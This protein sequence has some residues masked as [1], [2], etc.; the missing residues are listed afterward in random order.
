[1]GGPALLQKKTLEGV[2]PS[3]QQKKIQELLKK[4][5]AVVRVD[6]GIVHDDK[7]RKAANGVMGRLAESD[8]DMTMQEFLATLMRTHPED[9]KD[10]IRHMNGA[11]RKGNALMEEIKEIGTEYMNEPVYQKAYKK[12]LDTEILLD[13]ARDIYNKEKQDQEA[14]IRA[15]LSASRKGL[16]KEMLEEASELKTRMTELMDIATELEKKAQELSARSKQLEKPGRVWSEEEKKKRAGQLEK[17]HKERSELIDAINEMRMEI[18]GIAEYASEIEKRARSNQS[19]ISAWWGLSEAGIQA[20]HLL[21]SAEVLGNKLNEIEGRMGIRPYPTIGEQSF[22]KPLRPKVLQV[23]GTGVDKLIVPGQLHYLDLERGNIIN[24]VGVQALDQMYLRLAKG[25]RRIRFLE[26]AEFW[27]LVPLLPK[28]DAILKDMKVWKE[29][30]Y[31]EGFVVRV[32]LNLAFAGL[33]VTIIGKLATTTGARVTGRDLASSIAK[34]GGRFA[35]TRAERDVFL[36]ALQGLEKKDF[37]DLWR[38]ARPPSGGGLGWRRVCN[39][40]AR[41]A[42]SRRIT[43]SIIEEYVHQQTK[44]M[45]GIRHIWRAKAGT[46]DILSSSRALTG[47]ERFM[48]RVYAEIPNELRKTIDRNA[49]K[50]L[51][52]HLRSASLSM[53]E[54]RIARDSVFLVST[55]F[56][57]RAQ[58][59]LLKVVREKG[60]RYVAREI[61]SEIYAAEKQGIENA[62]SVGMKKGLGRV[63]PEYHAAYG[64][65]PLLKHV[66]GHSAAYFVIAPIVW[67]G[68][69]KVLGEVFP[70][71]KVGVVYTDLSSEERAM[72]AFRK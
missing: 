62:L 12:I 59:A 3:P 51:M 70:E 15:L 64:V 14:G 21:G 50:E 52:A 38:L 67:L 35:L 31:P 39:D 32:M 36:E 44:S 7:F 58:R 20:R 68:A 27:E 18:S 5:E 29:H 66:F 8:P 24:E 61:R 55:S 37:A 56:S 40:L 6:L 13:V 22:Y 57:P 46:R 69:M 60:W 41:F 11:I 43:A 28:F 48:Q 23:P 25:E 49:G 45:L 2:V 4:L 47:K 17:L 30:G 16:N 54:R 9:A 10:I 71:K 53:T 42:G 1:M 65:G 72:E 19:K 34:N 63:V 33:D 26:P